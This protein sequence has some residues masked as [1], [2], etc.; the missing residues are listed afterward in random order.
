MPRV[1]GGTGTVFAKEHPASNHKADGP[2]F[3]SSVIEF[4]CARAA[5]KNGPHHARMGAKINCVCN[6][7]TIKINWPTYNISDVALNCTQANGGEV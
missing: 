1:L 2:H 3:T 6:V 5:P 7:K 4:C